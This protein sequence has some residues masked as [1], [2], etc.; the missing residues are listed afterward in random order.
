MMIRLSRRKLARYTAERILAGDNSIINELAALIVE[1]RREREIDLLVLDIEEQLASRGLVVA[2]V[3]SAVP[4]SETLR[5]SVI[6][7]LGSNKMRL[8]EVVKPELIGGVRIASPT[9][10]FDGTVAKKLYELKSRKI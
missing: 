2:T 8:R 4:L 10:E 5:Q 7:F 3:E 6:S 9:Q 1:E